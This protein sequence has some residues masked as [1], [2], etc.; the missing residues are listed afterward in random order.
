M[1]VLKTYSSLYPNPQSLRIPTIIPLRTAQLLPI[2]PRSHHLTRHLFR[3]TTNPVAILSQNFQTTGAFSRMYCSIS[4]RE[5]VML[6]ALTVFTPLR[7]WR[8][9]AL[10]S[11]SI[12][13]TSPSI[14]LKNISCM[15]SC[16]GFV[17]RPSHNPMTSPHPAPLKNPCRAC[18]RLGSGFRVHSFRNPCMVRNSFLIN[19]MIAS[20]FG[21]CS[22]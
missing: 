17:D 10:V 6:P 20:S 1:M 18:E 12:F 9:G 7:A 16:R 15:S 11:F 8:I 3:R 4:F 13:T 5:V 14:S 19:A 2:T 21:A 22:L